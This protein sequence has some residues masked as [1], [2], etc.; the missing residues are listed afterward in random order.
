MM[1][2]S[3][4]IQRDVLLLVAKEESLSSWHVWIAVAAGLMAGEGIWDVVVVGLS[5][6]FGVRVRIGWRKMLGLLRALR[7]EWNVCSRR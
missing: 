2:L 6:D 3:R 7:F 5:G 4:T 1:R